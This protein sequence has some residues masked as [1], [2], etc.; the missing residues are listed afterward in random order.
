VS[1][2]DALRATEASGA[3]RRCHGRRGTAL[4]SALVLLFAFTSA[5]VVLLARD[6][7]DRVATRSSA[8]AIAFQA[9]RV[10]AQQIDVDRLRVDGSVSVDVERARRAA[11]AA[12]RDLLGRYGE[13]G[14]V[15]ATVED[16]RV[17]VVV[18]IIDVVVGGFDGAR[19]GV[20]RAEGIA[21]PESG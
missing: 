14:S 3:P 20:V 18:E 9:A 13:R 17:V 11:E 8:Q 19:T 5:G 1:R 12:G 15:V 16:D 6:Y 2:V 21:R 7:D 4:V 10:G